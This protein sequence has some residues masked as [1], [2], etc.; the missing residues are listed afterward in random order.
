MRQPVALG[1]Y[2]GDKKE[3]ENAVKS[4]LVSKIKIENAKGII[5]PHAGYAYSG[6]V[7]GAAY[8]SLNTDKRNFIML[9]PNHT[10]RGPAAALSADSWKTPLGEV[11]T[12][13]SLA[14]RLSKTIP[15]DESAHRHEHSLEVQLPFLQ[16]MRSN[17]TITPVCLSHLSF[18]AIE[19]LAYALLDENSFYIASSDF[20]HFGPNYGY[21]P[22]SADIRTAVAWVKSVDKRLIELICKL[23]A[24]SFYNEVEENGY[25]VCGYVPITLLLLTM[26]KLGAKKAELIKYATSY[27]IHPSSSFVSYAGIVFE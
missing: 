6:Y 10:G 17:F 27:E 11:M 2:P 9:G 16:V 3:L 12:D 20:I 23:D 26:K 1:F 21:Q 15:V 4:M 25:T 22:I 7:A 19:K 14:E 13:A 24:K 5:V 8:A 18:A